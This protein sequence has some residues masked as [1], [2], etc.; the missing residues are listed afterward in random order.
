MR[1]NIGNCL[2]NDTSKSLFFWIQSVVTSLCNSY[3]HPFIIFREFWLCSV[4]ISI[5]SWNHLSSIGGSSF[6]I[7]YKLSFINTSAG[8][9]HASR[10]CPSYEICSS[11]YFK[12]PAFYGL[13]HIHF[14]MLLSHTAIAH[15]RSSPLLN[16]SFFLAHLVSLMCWR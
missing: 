14:P 13:K 7:F 4:K 8:N 5:Y 6:C 16:P 2:I 3:P 9:A 10:S 12:H 11:Y 15:Q 1:Y